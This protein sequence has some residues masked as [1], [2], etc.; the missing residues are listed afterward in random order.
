MREEPKRKEGTRLE[1]YTSRIEKSAGE[2]LSASRQ[3]DEFAYGDILPPP[4]EPKNLISLV[5]R[6]DTILQ[7]VEAMATNVALFGHAIKWSDEFDY[8]KAQDSIKREAEKEWDLLRIKYKNISPM[9]DFSQLL[10]KAMVDKYTIGWGCLE[11]IRGATNEVST[12]E[13]MRACNVRIAKNKEARTIIK[14]WEESENEKYIQNDTPVKFKKFVQ[15]INGEKVYFKEFGDPRQMNCKNGEYI[16]DSEN[17][18]EADQAT[19]VIFFPSHSTYTDYGVPFW[20]NTAISAS[21]STMADTLNYKYFSDGRILPMAV[22]VSGGQLTQ[23]SI[24]AIRDGK[25]VENAYKIMVLEA[26]PEKK[27]SG[28]ESENTPA[29]KI[30][31]KSLTDTN[32]SDALFQ[33]YQKQ[34]K[35][36]IRDASRLPLIFTG[37]S[38]DYT[39]ATA[40]VARAIAEEQIF[41]PERKNICAKFNKIINNE[42]QVKYCELYLKGAVLSDLESKNAMLKTL[43]EAGALTPNMVL[44]LA[45]QLL[46]KDL[47]PWDQ[48]LGNIPFKLLLQREASEQSNSEEENNS[49]ELESLSVVKNE[50]KKS[51]SEV[52]R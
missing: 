4:Y 17:L 41:F 26:L 38:G 36:K 43:D 9:E 40:D 6:N 10:Y 39:R 42:H 3:L 37:A 24:Q 33:E 25:G 32:N 31:I 49:K 45:G 14:M 51:L 22:T 7:L 19:E 34:S 35:E 11:V 30:D 2:A 47:E 8:N 48:D 23:G 12:L 27:G 50:I 29:T 16:K 46:N 20:I 5:E 1:E 13:Y 28:L 18:S 44:D 15:V 21:G 52:I